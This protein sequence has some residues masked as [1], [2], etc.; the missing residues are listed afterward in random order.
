MNTKIT[1]SEEVASGKT[2]VGKLLA[3]RMGYEF[4][5]LGNLVRKK[6]EK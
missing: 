2:T 4:I 6:A 3:E 5:S 1:L